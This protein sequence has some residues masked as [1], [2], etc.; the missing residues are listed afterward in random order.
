MR[1]TKITIQDF[2]SFSSDKKAPSTEI[3]L[4]PGVNYFAGANNVGKSN[5]LRAV[6]LALD[7]RAQF[8][9]D[10]DN[11]NDNQ[12]FVFSSIT[13]EFIAGPDR[14]KN[15]E[16]LLDRVDH[17]ERNK[18]KGFVA[19]SLA[20]QGIIR[21]VARFDGI[22]RIEG[23][24]TR[25]S[26]TKSG[27]DFHIALRLF[28]K[29]VR[30]VDIK[31]GEDLQS[32]LRRGFSEIL[33][34]A[35]GDEH[36]EEMKVVREARE[37]YINAL[38]RMLRPV[39][40]H[41]EDRMRR[42]VRGIEEVDLVPDVPSV[43]ESIAHTRIFLKDT[44]RTALE[45]K[46]TGVRG[47]ALLLLL[48]FIAE[49]SKNTVI[50]GIEEPETFLHPETH[51][52]LGAGLERFTQRSDVT[53]LVTTHSPFI[54][55]STTDADRVGVFHVTKDE[56]G[57]SIVVRGSLKE[58]RTD[59][60]GSGELSELLEKVERV[61]DDAKLLL[62]VEGETDR[63]YLG[64]ASR[65]LSL[66]LTG[67]HILPRGGAAGA[68]LEA[69]ALGARHTPGR[70][71]A[72][73][74][75]SDETGRESYKLLA[76]RFGWK[77]R[78]G[79]RLFVLSYDQWLDSHGVPVEAEDLFTNVTMEAFLAAAPGNDKFCT[80]KVKRKKTG[81]WHYGLDTQGK[82]AFVAWLA[83]N[84]DEAMFEQWRTVVQHLQQIAGGTCT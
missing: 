23:F 59:L 16:H 55:R 60:F 19:P 75:D 54:F 69:V 28:H 84:G 52:E 36:A 26:A 29:V 37:A 22:R 25:D 4:A 41:V 79:E 38:G 13:L 2:R 32:L 78:L 14:S 10:S 67:V 35:V 50:F 24:L 17:Y 53:L 57:R 63:S 70:A 6:E 43:E 77:K 5:L 48:S 1:L 27:E 18:V 82:I 44:F 33:G 8:N 45:Q 73:L 51:R 65:H 81:V 11:P 74:F 46:G 58:V 47:A 12:D 66:P 61:P 62:V 9:L 49:S 20:S 76:D 71:V 30:F 39:A 64:L 83:A 31:S 15:V 34:S 3:E 40:K 21:F 7:P 80:E 42:Y 68:V 72:A 56:S